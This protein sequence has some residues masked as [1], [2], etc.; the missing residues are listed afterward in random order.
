MN[1][2]LAY[3]EEFREELIGGEIVAMSPRPTF[4]HN[5]IAFN[6]AFIF[7]DYLR[8]KHCTVIPDGTDLYLTE[9]DRFIPDMMAVCDRDKIKRDGVHGVTDLVV[10][11][12]SPSH[13][14]YSDEALER[15][16]EK[17]RAEIVTH[18]K[19]SLYDDF[20]IALDDIFSGLLS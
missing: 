14:S 8:G 6:V 11:V 4:N 7:Q 3:Q 19:C 20:D 2:N 5:H 15:M 18:F 10:E 9:E 12:L 17:E 1:S 16:T 13:V